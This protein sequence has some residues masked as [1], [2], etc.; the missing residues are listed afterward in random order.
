M[1]RADTPPS[2]PGDS[3]LSHLPCHLPVLVEGLPECPFLSLPYWSPLC[4]SLF[5]LR[6]PVSGTCVAPCPPSVRLGPYPLGCPLTLARVPSSCPYRLTRHVTKF[7]ESHRRIPYL[8][9]SHCPT[10][11]LGS[12]R[13]RP[14]VG[15]REFYGSR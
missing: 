4:L 11:S 15:H 12:F 5:R 6:F 13:R 9:E 7:Q 3:V 8:T 10:G 1:C 14:L 2:V